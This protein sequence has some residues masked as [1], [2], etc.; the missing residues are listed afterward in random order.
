MANNSI[1]V[2][3]KTEY[4]IE[5]NDKGE[6][7]SFDTAD[8]GLTSRMFKMYE[9]IDRLTKKYEA[10]GKEIDARP[11]EPYSTFEVTNE[12]TGETETKTLLTKN[13]FDGAQM[14]DSFYNESRKALDEFLG[15]GACQK[16]FGNKNY[17]AMF[18]DLLEQLQPQF[19]AMGINAE[20]IKT[21]AANK[22]KPKREQRRALK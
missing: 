18:N 14:I 19:K 6:T 13:Q 11:D 20:K 22:H 5:V 4:V 17:T 2:Q 9:A 8:T 1:R 10:Q 21:A 7:I 3:S 12:E 16:I 15:E